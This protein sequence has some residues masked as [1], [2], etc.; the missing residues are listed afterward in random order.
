MM[1]FEFA[2]AGRILFGAGRIREV[3]GTAA[4]M[5]THALLLCGRD[6]ERA[7]PL[8]KEL[9]AAGMNVCVFRI[10][11]EP[12]TDRVIQ[13]SEFARKQQCDTVIAMGGGS[14]LDAAKAIAALMRNSGDLFDYLEIVGKGRSIENDP[15]PCIAIPTTAGTGAE[16]TCNAVLESRKHKVKVSMRSPRMLPRLAV[17]DPELTLSQPP[18]ITASCGM[19][20]LTQLIEA[21][22]GRNANP[23][24][25]G[26]CREGIRRAG[27]S[28]QKAYEQGNDLPAREDMCLAALLGG[29]ALANA[30]LGAVH[31]MAAPLGGMFSLAHGT[32]CAA[33]LPHV[34]EV[35]IR[36]LSQRDADS[37]SLQRYHEIGKILCENPEALAQDGLSRIQAI[38]RALHIPPLREFHLT[39]KDAEMIIPKA[40]NASSMKGNPLMLTHGEMREILQKS[41]QE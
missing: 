21:F 11:G 14:V 8:K 7:A 1:K 32:V 12:D 28:L 22:V 30:K 18:E 23:L 9:E 31:G 10:P 27:R 29:L 15:A 20:A 24:T 5:G 13:G 25:D 33:L 6:P 40:R 16:V 35:N 2:T 26:I 41:I 36:A 17:A 19:D 38:C 4:E 3:P 34:M 37:P 39:E